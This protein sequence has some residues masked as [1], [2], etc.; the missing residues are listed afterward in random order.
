MIDPSSPPLVQRLR[1]PSYLE[2]LVESLRMEAACAEISSGNGGPNWRGGMALIAKKFTAAADEL[3][4]RHQAAIDRELELSAYRVEIE[5][6]WREVEIRTEKLDCVLA[7]EIE[8]RAALERIERTADWIEGPSNS[9]DALHIIADIARA[10]LADP[11]AK[12]TAENGT[13]STSLSTTA[14]TK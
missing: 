13:A 4:R 10:A 3:E 12:G 14:R 2:R 6:L 8:L 5:R 1:E 7:R 11:V 9:E